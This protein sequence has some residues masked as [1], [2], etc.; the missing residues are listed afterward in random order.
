M[1]Y[2]KHH[3]RNKIGLSRTRKQ[4]WKCWW[5]W[6]SVLGILI[7]FLALYFFLFYSGFQVLDIKIYGNQKVSNENILKAVDDKI[8]HK[9]LNIGNLKINSKSIFIANKKDIAKQISDN[10][11]IIEKVIVKKILPRSISVSVEERKPVGVFCNKK[12]D[13]F[14][15]DQHGIIFEKISEIPTDMFIVRQEFGDTDP[16][17]G[18]QAVS[19]VVIGAIAKAQKKL[20]DDFN[21]SITD[22]ALSSQIRLDIS[23]SEGW[24][25]YLSLDEDADINSQLNS[26]L[27]MLGGEITPEIRESLQYI[28]L[29]FKNRAY[30]K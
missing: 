18:T 13:C 14:F 5:F 28:D 1:L 20:K 26:L 9:Y 6:Y 22:V 10:F 7:L 21:I 16:N 29:R 4:F 15:V 24:K 27:I 30:Y 12:E 17:I 2:R 8:V 23:T 3:V 25:V 19:D 11:P